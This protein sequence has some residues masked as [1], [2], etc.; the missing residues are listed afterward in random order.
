MFA[1]RIAH[2]GAEGGG[3]GIEPFNRGGKSGGVG[4]IGD[5]DDGPLAEEPARYSQAAAMNTQTH[6]Q[7]VRTA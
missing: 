3:G 2:C 5:G 6:H 4:H 1:K 7:N